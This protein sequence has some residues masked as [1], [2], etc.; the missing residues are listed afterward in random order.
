MKKIDKLTPQQEAQ[1]EVYSKKWIDIGLKVGPTN[2]ENARKAIELAYKNAGLEAPKEFYHVK[3]PIAAAELIKSIHP[4]ISSQEIMNSTIYA[5]HDASWLSF[6]EYCRDELN[7]ECCNKL[8]GLIELAYHSGWVNV[9]DSF[10]VIQDRPLYIKMDEQNRLHCSDGPA[11]EYGDGL[12]I[13]SISGV[14]IPG[15]WIEDKKSLTAKIAI[16]WQNVEQRRI[17][18]EL[19]GWHR[20]I[21]ELNGKAIDIHPN[22]EVGVLYE[23][24]FPEIGKE[25]FLQVLCGT[26]R[27]FAIPVPGDMKT[28]L[29]AQAWTWGLTEDEFIIPEVRT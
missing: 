15:E 17:A 14:A 25:K 18:C 7:L 6:Y 19:V 24:E 12:K 8:N 13:Y 4:E 3:G 23:V 11:I 26:K 29:Q 27:T 21:D 28:A 5:Y 16:R 9:F 20:I 2:I 1:L 22:P 10:V